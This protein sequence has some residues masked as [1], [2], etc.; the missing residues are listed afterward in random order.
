MPMRQCVIH[1]GF[2]NPMNRPSTS[3]SHLGPSTPWQVST[4]ICPISITQVASAALLGRFRHFERR[5]IPAAELGLYPGSRVH[6]LD[7]VDLR[8][9]IEPCPGDAKTKKVTLALDTC[10]PGQYPLQENLRISK[11]P[12]CNDRST[13][14]VRFTREEAA[15]GR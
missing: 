12:F 8:Q 14:T 3:S 4:S 9:K 13:A 7:L 1:H 11:L 10:L 15:L 6:P 5:S 2:V